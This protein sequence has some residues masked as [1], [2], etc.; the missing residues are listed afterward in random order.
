MV[1]QEAGVVQVL[2]SKAAI[3]G[4]DAAGQAC[5]PGVEGLCAQ[6]FAG[7]GVRDQGLGA[8]QGIDLRWIHHETAQV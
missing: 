8:L 1:E 5:A 7:W 6:R 4:G 3:R 2:P